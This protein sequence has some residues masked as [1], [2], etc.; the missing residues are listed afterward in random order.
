[1]WLKSL[2]LGEQIWRSVTP[3][4]DHYCFGGLNAGDAA[5]F[6]SR[7]AIKIRLIGEQAP[8]NNILPAG[9]Y[10]H[11]NHIRESTEPVSDCTQLSMR[12]LDTC[13]CQ[14]IVPQS[15]CIGK[16]PNPDNLAVQEPTESLA[17]SGP[18]DAQFTGQM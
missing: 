1:V 12:Y 18:T 13:H 14:G 15:Q 10:D 8:D 6:P 11:R 5:Q 16:G 2:P 9:R 17:G 4:D 7:E 3:L